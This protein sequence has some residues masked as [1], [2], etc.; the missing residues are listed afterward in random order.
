MSAAAKAKQPF[1]KIRSLVER[2]KLVEEVIR[3][4]DELLCKGDGDLLFNVVPKFV[5]QDI[6][7]QKM[8]LKGVLKPADGD[9]AAFQSLQEESTNKHEIVGNFSVGEQ[10]Y[11]LRGQMIILKPW[12]FIPLECEVY[13][14]QRRSSL[15]LSLPPEFP[16]MI[17][18]LDFNKD[19]LFNIAR[20]ADVSAGGAKIYFSGAKSTFGVQDNSKDPGLKVGSIFRVIV[21]PPS[22]KNI[23]CHCEVKHSKEEV[24]DGEKRMAFGCSF[25]QL[26]PSHVA[27]LTAMTLDLQR[28]LMND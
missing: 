21:K 22:G 18:I 2:R 13:H 10:R 16:F 17:T 28:K 26:N 15:R 25:V 9:A 7:T 4:G 23:E 8:I 6:A 14:F 27:R 5:E 20:V 24:I 1:E 11:F 12:I 3:Q 19:N